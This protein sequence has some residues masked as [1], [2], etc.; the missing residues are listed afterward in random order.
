LTLPAAAPTRVAGVDVTVVGSGLPVT[1]FAH[2]LGG[3][4][5]ET[6]P[7]ALRTQGTRL[8]LTFRGHGA[9]DTIA[10]GWSYDDLAD[11]LAAVADAF[12]ATA[13]V[14]LSLGSG[15]LLRLLSREPGRFARLAFVLP[16]ALDE[17]RDDLATERLLRLADAM[18]VGDEEL[19]VRLLLS[20]VPESVRERGGTR[21]LVDRRARQLLSTTP[22][23]PRA[24]E[25]PLHDL[26]P[27]AAVTAPALVVGQ[28]GDALHPSAVADRLAA[29]LPSARLLQLEPGGV[30][31]TATRQVQD[32]LAHHLVPEA[33]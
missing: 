15:A 11:D 2:G 28:A 12:D 24:P 30:F 29:A 33:P 7:L 16:A 6:R 14:G 1:V 9:S 17:T 19:V 22:P 21:L 13:A 31:W 3:S 10:G 5:V 25:A 8:L 18:I 4:S 32:A 20:E 26:T 23:M 27:L